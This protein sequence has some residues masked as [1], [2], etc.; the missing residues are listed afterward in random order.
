MSS[1]DSDKIV[2]RTATKSDDEKARQVQQNYQKGLE[3]YNTK[4]KQTVTTTAKTLTTITTTT[5][6]VTSTA[7]QTITPTTSS[8]VPAAA[9]STAAAALGDVILPHASA[10]DPVQSQPAKQPSPYKQPVVY[11]TQ[12]TT[13]KVTNTHTVTSPAATLNAGTNFAPSTFTASS[14][15]NSNNSLTDIETDDME[16][17]STFLPRP[18]TGLSTDTQN[19]DEFLKD[20]QSYISIKKLT[21][22]AAVQMVRMCLRDNAR[23]YFDTLPAEDRETLTK[24]DAALRTQYGNELKQWSLLGNLWQIKQKPSQNFESY[25]V[26]MEKEA[27]KISELPIDTLRLAVINGML[28]HL[29]KQFI[30]ASMDGSIENMRKYAKATGIDVETEDDK[31]ELRDTLKDIQ[32]SIEE[33]KNKPPVYV[34]NQRGGGP[35]RINNSTRPNGGAWNTIGEADERSDWSQGPRQPAWQMPGNNPSQF[36]P[37]YDPRL[38]RPAGHGYSPSQYRLGNGPSQRRPGNIPSPPGFGNA[39][40]QPRFGASTA[41]DGTARAARWSGQPEWPNEQNRGGN[42]STFYRTRGQGGQQGRRSNDQSNR[43]P[44]QSDINQGTAP[45]EFVNNNRAEQYQTAMNYCHYCNK[46]GHT[47]EVCWNRNRVPHNS[48]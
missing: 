2:T 6:P 8:K 27:Q 19:I 48:Y 36:R 16:S 25:L 7:G 1:S 4:P 13:V 17:P 26:Q 46:G 24:V 45:T 42:T 30:A 39:P 15:Y 33:M 35:R 29:R 47:I 38:M 11:V 10:A 31:P 37:G 40:S 23:H 9:G 18:F 12:D 20:I 21:G 41:N 32:A 22:E 14:Q 44:M 28:P 5:A 43:R 34:L 3:A